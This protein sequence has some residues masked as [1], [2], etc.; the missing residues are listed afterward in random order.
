[1]SGLLLILTFAFLIAAAS[2]YSS[3]FDQ[4]TPWFPPEFRDASRVRV[5]LDVLIWDRSFPVEARRKYLL[6]LGLAAVAMLCA[7]IFLQ[8]QDQFVGAV[9]FACLFV[10]GVGCVLVR[11]VKYK[12]RL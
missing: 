3:A 2:F 9:C 1:M 8:L 7:A 12:D 6:S 4:A 10:L 11:W 5:A